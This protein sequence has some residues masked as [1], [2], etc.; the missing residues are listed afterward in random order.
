MTKH[1]KFLICARR[2]R[3]DTQERYFYEWGNIHVSLMLTTPEVMQVFKR[4]VQHYSISGIT[5]DMLVFPL[6]AMAWDNMADHW[7]DGYEDFLTSLHAESYVQR[8]QPHN[9]GDKEFVLALTTGDVMYEKPGF[10]SGGVKL[11]HWLKKKPGLSQ[12]E[13][14]AHWRERYAPVFLKAA[15]GHGLVRKYVRSEQLELDAE[16][17]KG[18]LFEFG[19]VGAYAGVEEFWF[20]DVESLAQM[21]RNPAI[22][23][24]II[25]G[26]AEFVD[27]ENS[28]SMVTTERVVYDFVTPSELSPPPA[29]L[30]P[31]SLE[32]RVVAQGYR[33][34]NIPKPVQDV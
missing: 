20:K 18:S 22:Y 29:V 30:N 11:V 2:K 6:S 26:M 23:D 17:F 21:R 9:F 27:M 16:V 25:G 5:S 32:A 24:A 34:W 14:N 28:F 1:I 7:L 4:Y 12:C 15:E 33:G 10:R 19:G 3:E 8:M 13:F 31:D